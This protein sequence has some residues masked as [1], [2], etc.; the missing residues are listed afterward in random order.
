MTRNWTCL[1]Y[2]L[3]LGMVEIT[4]SR[5]PTSIVAASLAVLAVSVSV[6]AFQ[7]K[8]IQSLLSNGSSIGRIAPMVAGIG[9]TGLPV[10]VSA[11]AAIPTVFYYFDPV[12]SWCERNWANIRTLSREQ[13]GRYRLIGLSDKRVDASYLAQRGLDLQVVGGIDARTR[14]AFGLRG[15]P[16]TVMVSSDGIITHDWVGAFTPVLQR[17]IEDVF[18][19]ALP[20]LVSRP[21]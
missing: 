7:A 21:D 9:P 12:C 20:G 4:M 16:H 1:V 17:R 3:H 5:T 14:A 19:L 15:T 10:S 13:H 6:N 8:R 11:A 18:Q 2:C